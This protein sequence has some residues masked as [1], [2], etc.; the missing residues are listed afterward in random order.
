MCWKRIFTG[1]SPWWNQNDDSSL[2]DFIRKFNSLR[3]EKSIASRAKQGRNVDK[4]IEH[5]GWVCWSRRRSRRTQKRH[6]P[7]IKWRISRKARRQRRTLEW[8]WFNYQWQPKI[9]T[10]TKEN[11]NYIWRKETRRRL[12]KHHFLMNRFFHKIK[13]AYMQNKNFLTLW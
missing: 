9:I 2:P 4:N 8:S 6:I 5:R 13:F 1:K 11:F 3:Y 7:K 10:G 12:K